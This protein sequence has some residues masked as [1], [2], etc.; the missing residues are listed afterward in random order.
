MP[1]PASAALVDF[2]D[3]WWKSPPAAAAARGEDG[4][5]DDA[6]DDCRERDRRYYGSVDDD[7]DDEERG[8]GRLILDAIVDFCDRPSLYPQA[9]G[10]Q[11]VDRALSDISGTSTS[12]DDDDDDSYDSGSGDSSGS[13]SRDED[14]GERE[15]E[16]PHRTLGLIFFDFVRC[17]AVSANMRCVST[18]LMP[19]FL[20]WGMGQGKVDAL[21]AALR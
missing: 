10:P 5:G 13:G 9:C 15:I 16:Q 12:G 14:D 17:V 21:S 18:Q 6:G 3:V 7:E 1:P 2:P 19:L 20:A 4:V 8:G 11:D